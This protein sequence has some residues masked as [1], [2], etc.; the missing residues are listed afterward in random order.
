MSNYTARTNNIGHYI[1]G[2]I[3][4]N[5][6][7]DLLMAI[8][9]QLPN[10]SDLLTADFDFIAA[11]KWLDDHAKSVLSSIGTVNLFDEA[12]S[13]D[14]ALE[15]ANRYNDAAVQLKALALNMPG[16]PAAIID[17]YHN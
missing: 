8:G 9:S 17:Y 15:R 2:L 14:Q 6:L 13:A 5:P 16:T 11:D 3:N 10:D 7:D 4:Q 1:A 12:I